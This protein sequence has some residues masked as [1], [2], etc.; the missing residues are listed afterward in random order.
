MS[1]PARERMNAC[2][3]VRRDDDPSYDGAII[4]LMMMDTVR[5]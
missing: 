5:V 4:W 3:R 2:A 1:P